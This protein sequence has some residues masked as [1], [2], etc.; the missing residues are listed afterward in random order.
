MK[1]SA[2]IKERIIEATIILITESDGDVAEIN[3]RAIAEKANVGVGMINYHFQTK[4]NLIEICVEQIIGKVIA[5]F[6][7]TITE[8]TPIAQLKHTVK[9]VFD[10]LMSNPAVSKISILSDHKNPK[11]TDNTIKTAIGLNRTLG[12]FEMSNKRQ[13][14]LTFALTSIMQAIFLRKNQFGEL[15][16]C[17]INIK[18]QRDKILDLFVDNLVGGHNCE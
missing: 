1:K 5:A 9:L 7:P 18:A 16:G 15:F 11:K 8:S 4:D 12:D 14:L 10:F 6:A 2:E 3:T 17:D 13:F